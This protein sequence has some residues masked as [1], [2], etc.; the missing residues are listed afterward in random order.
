MRLAPKDPDAVKDYRIDLTE[1]LSGDTI[2]STSWTVPSGIT[3][4]SDTNTTLTATIWLSGGTAGQEYDLICRVVT[5]DGRTEDFTVTVPVRESVAFNVYGTVANVAALTGRYTSS[6]EF[7]SSTR[8]TKADV[9]GFIN[10]IS[11]LV[12]VLLAEQGFSIPVTQMDAKLAIDDFVINQVV[13]LCHAANGAGP[14]APGSESLRGQT[15]MKIVLKEAE[16]FIGDHAA[17]LEA[18]GAA[19]TRD[20][21][22]GL[23]CREEDDSGDEIIP[24]FQREMIGHTIVNWDTNE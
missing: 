16:A 18:L 15:P 1:W 3:K 5:V 20:L 7:T 10:R 24:P 13:Q 22:F 17:G 14:Y 8:P 4:D 2:S 19:R 6:G 11:A 23:Q 21:S 9:Q 12:N